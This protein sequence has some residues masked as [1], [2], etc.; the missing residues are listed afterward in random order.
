MSWYSFRKFKS[1]PLLLYFSDNTVWVNGDRHNLT[2]FFSLLGYLVVIFDVLGSVPNFVS[3]EERQDAVSF[4][5][6]VGLV[7][8]I[9]QEQMSIGVTAQSNSMKDVP[10]KHLVAKWTKHCKCSVSSEYPCLL[11]HWRLMKKASLNSLHKASS[12][13]WCPFPRPIFWQ[14]SYFW[15]LKIWKAHY[16]RSERNTLFVFYTVMGGNENITIEIFSVIYMF[17]KHSEVMCG[18]QSLMALWV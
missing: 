5:K 17:S 13:I 16:L 18:H 10:H 15:C 12:S 7:E 8:K 9:K 4:L 14:K 3:Y 1:V 2:E 11:C 6:R